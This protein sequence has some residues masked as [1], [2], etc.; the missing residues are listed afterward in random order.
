M[1]DQ[2]M[3]RSMCRA[4]YRVCLEVLGLTEQREGL[5][6][7]HQVLPGHHVVVLVQHAAAQAQQVAVLQHRRDPDTDIPHRL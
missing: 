2:G 5:G 4:T 6:R 3:K 7:H 1:P